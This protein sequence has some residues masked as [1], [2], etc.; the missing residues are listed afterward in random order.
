[1]AQTHYKERS[2]LFVIEINKPIKNPYPFIWPQPQNF[3]SGA[4][5]VFVD[6]WAFSY[7]SNVSSSDL[8]NAF[9]RY[10]ATIF[11]HSVHQSSGNIQG[12]SVNVRLCF[13]RT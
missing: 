10:N 1:M 7:L 4:A 12:V 2:Q 5:T 13:F 8:D 6:A 11:P 9:L 3:S